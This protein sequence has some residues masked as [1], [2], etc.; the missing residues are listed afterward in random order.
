MTSMKPCATRVSSLK[1]RPTA[2]SAHRASCCIRATALSEPRI[3]RLHRIAGAVEFAQV[4]QPVHR[5]PMRVLLAGLEQCGDVLGHLGARLRAGGGAAVLQEI[6]GLHD[7]VDT[8]F[9]GFLVLQLA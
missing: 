4:S 9:H 7:A 1:T 8:G 5:Q 2:W 6:I 3:P